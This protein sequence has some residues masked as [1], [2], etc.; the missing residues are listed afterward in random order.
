MGWDEIKKGVNLANVLNAEAQYY[1][2]MGVKTFKKYNLTPPNN[3][4]QKSNT[5]C[6]PSHCCPTFMAIGVLSNPRTF[7]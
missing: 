4:A 2:L 3:W 1:M 6:A 7:T 5:V